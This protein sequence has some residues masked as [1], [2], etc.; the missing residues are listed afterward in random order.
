VRLLPSVPKKRKKSESKSTKSK[1]F[2][3]HCRDPIGT[4]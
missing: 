4:Q 3:R 1:P 2:F